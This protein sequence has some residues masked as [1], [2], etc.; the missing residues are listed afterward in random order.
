[1]REGYIIPFRLVSDNSRQA[2]R[3]LGIG[4]E[5]PRFG[6]IARETTI[7]LEK[8]GTIHWLHVGET[9][10]DRPSVDEILHP[11]LNPQHLPEQEMPHDLYARSWGIYLTSYFCTLDPEA[12]A[13]A[14]TPTT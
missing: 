4:E 8:G 11:D 7:L 3:K 14:G 2:I 9:L 13:F 10:R 6:L 12:P 5:H 1:M